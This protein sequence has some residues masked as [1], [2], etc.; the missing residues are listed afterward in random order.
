MTHNDAR[1]HSRIVSTSSADCRS[2]V[3]PRCRQ[4]WLANRRASVRFDVRG[5]DFARVVAEF[6]PP[7]ADEH[8]ILRDTTETLNNWIERTFGEFTPK[9]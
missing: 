1:H 3:S 4:R 8:P 5:E 6:E 2:Q 9:G 7:V